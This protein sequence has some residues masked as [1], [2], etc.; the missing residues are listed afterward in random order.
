MTY[1]PDR[2]TRRDS[3]AYLADTWRAE[4]RAAQHSPPDCR[5]THDYRTN[6]RG[7]GTCHHCGDTINWEEL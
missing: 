6:S 7:G 4:T 5:D 2:D 3:A 1:A